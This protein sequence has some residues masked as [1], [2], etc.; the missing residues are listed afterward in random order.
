[1]SQKS[2]KRNALIGKRKAPG[3]GRRKI[4]IAI[5][6]A[7]CVYTESQIWRLVKRLQAQ[8]EWEVT[9]V[10]TDEATRKAA[11]DQGVQSTVIRLTPRQA[12]WDEQLAT[13]NELI[14]KTSDIVIPGTQLPFS[15]HGTRQ[16]R[17]P[18]FFWGQPAI[19]LNVDL[20]IVPLMRGPQHVE[21]VDSTPLS[22][23]SAAQGI[24]S[25]LQ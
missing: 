16:F 22:C 18:C 23:A 21:C 19:S 5:G 20:V 4:L 9:C 3:G 13:V 7:E 12:K 25:R 10:T 14:S 15:T 11:A 8:A 17:V 2:A 24:D 1:V 6:D